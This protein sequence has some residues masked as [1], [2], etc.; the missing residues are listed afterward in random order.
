M[1]TKLKTSSEEGMRLLI[2]KLLTLRVENK[3]A[4]EFNVLKFKKLTLRESQSIQVIDI[5]KEFKE[6]VSN[7]PLIYHSPL[8]PIMALNEFNAEFDKFIGNEN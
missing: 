7:L 5:N 2:R 8:V 4:F 6:I 1:E 3:L